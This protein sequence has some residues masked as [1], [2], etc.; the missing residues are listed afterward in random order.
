MLALFL[1][2]EYRL[3]VYRFYLAFQ[4]T[5]P[6]SWGSWILLGIYPA[7]LA[8]GLA[9]LREEEARWFGAP[10]ARLRAWLGE[11]LGILQW[12][13]LAL[14]AGLGIYT[15]I[16]LSGLGV[17]RPVWN[18]AMLGP[19]FLVSGLSTGA[20]LMMLFPLNH[21]EHTSLRRWDLL[22]IGVEALLLFL[23][24]ASLVT[25]G[26]QAGREAASLVLG[27]AYTAP[28]WTLVVIVGLVLPFVIK[29]LEG[30]R[31]LPPT[32]LAPVLVLIGGFSLR[33]ILVLAGQ[34]L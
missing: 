33:W 8:L 4:A 12:A 20:A 22:A 11:H 18:S 1:D 34:S 6:M 14:G 21:E 26:G 7:S 15:G 17:A 29:S 27:G 16:L 31:G 3:H 32:R 23:F 28:F 5:S 10:V 2:L 25:G 9:C 30:T 19:L 13:N 24:L